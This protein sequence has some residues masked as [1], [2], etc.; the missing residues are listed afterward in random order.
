M[1]FKN[2]ITL[3]S[4]MIALRHSL[5]KLCDKQPKMIVANGP[6][7]LLKSVFIFVEICSFQEA[8]YRICTNSATEDDLTMPICLAHPDRVMEYA[9]KWCRKLLVF[10]AIFILF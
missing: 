7:Y 2:E 4:C 9:M 1:V 8:Y 6:L 10:K 3:N 5:E